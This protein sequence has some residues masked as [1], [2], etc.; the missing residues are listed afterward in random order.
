VILY[1]LE[2]EW[3]KGVSARYTAVVPSIL[4]FAAQDEK[5]YVAEKLHMSPIE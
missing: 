4:P 5:Q 1:Q 2:V 3:A